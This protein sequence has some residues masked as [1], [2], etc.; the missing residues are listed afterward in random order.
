MPRTNTLSPGTRR[1]GTLRP[2]HT[3]LVAL[4]AVV[5][6]AAVGRLVYVAIARP[7]PTRYAAFHSTEGRVA[8]I[9]WPHC[10]S[11]RIIDGSRVWAYCRGTN[12]ASPFLDG[13]ARFDLP[14]ERA[15]LLWPTEIRDRRLFAFALTAGRDPLVAYEADGGVFEVLRLRDAGGVDVL[16]A[17]AGEAARSEPIAMAVV[18]E[19]VEVVT[20]G[21]VAPVVHRRPLGDGAWTSEPLFDEPCEEG[22][23]CRTA[24]AR[25]AA[26][27]W[28]VYRTRW[29]AIA[30]AEGAPTLEILESTGGASAR[31]VQR[32][33]LDRDRAY[34][35]T[36][37]SAWR[38]QVFLERSVGGG[39]TY[40]ASLDQDHVFEWQDG[41][42][43]PFVPLAGAF[44][45]GERIDVPDFLAVDGAL[46]WLP[47]VGFGPHAVRVDGRWLA[48]RAP[49][50]RQSVGP[51][52]G[53][54]G[55]N[56]AEDG[57]LTGDPALF[58][59]EDGDLWWLGAFG[60]FVR[61]D[62]QT[63]ARVDTPLFFERV[64][65]LYE[66]FHRLAAFNDFWLETP[67][68]KAAVLPIVLLLFP[69]G[70]ALAVGARRSQWL[71]AV[72]GVYL[73]LAGSSAWWFWRLTGWF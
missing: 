32:I 29:P 1:P 34:R 61:V 26:D 7:A 19:T 17:P 21:Y 4:A 27:G 64:A 65:L 20:G 55:P 31:V 56:V 57:W 59:A 39:V 47:S 28:H 46:R 14:G 22:N 58:P 45:G 11:P 35:E 9:D 16:G 53:P 68:A 63:F 43:T 62:G 52:G 71:P 73:V 66:N 13:F 70:A 60:T 40:G 51:L 18:G 30:P 25:L 49:Q 67:A 41:A 23:V 33:P 6:L 44:D 8:S 15:D 3:V 5:W 36:D 37:G 24:A 50:G 2:G 72:A 48:V 54:E 38:G 12:P 69:L 10:N 42:W